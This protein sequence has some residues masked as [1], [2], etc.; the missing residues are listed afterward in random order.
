MDRIENVTTEAIDTMVDT[1]VKG[2][3]YVTRAI[4]PIMKGRQ[5][6]HI[7]NI[8]SVSGIFFYMFLYWKM[9]IFFHN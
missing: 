7:I 2:L 4:L 9:I 8:G 5:K 3:L 1:N 6:G